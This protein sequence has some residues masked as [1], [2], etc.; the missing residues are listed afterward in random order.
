MVSNTSTVPAHY[1][2]ASHYRQV[3][4]RG[5]GDFLA[6]LIKMLARSSRSFLHATSLRAFR[7]L[8]HR[9]SIAALLKLPTAQQLPRRTFHASPCPR[10]GLSPESEEPQAPQPERDVATGG[11]H[12]ITEPADISADEYHEIADHYIDELVAELEEMAEDGGKGLEV[13]YSVR[14][15]C[16]PIAWQTIAPSP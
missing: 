13:E 5:R 4:A 12:H 8:H 1:S 16:D 7:S 14:S 9:P 11:S 10:K 15:L 2:T 6:S 3:E